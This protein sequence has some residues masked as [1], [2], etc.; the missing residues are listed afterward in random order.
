MKKIEDYI[1]VVPDALS[2][3]ECDYLLKYYKNSEWDMA[4]VDDHGRGFKPDEHV[5]NCYVTPVGQPRSYALMCAKADAAIKKY[6]E[7]TPLVVTR[8]NSGFDMLKYEEGGFYK[9]HADSMPQVPRVLS[10]SWALNDDFEGGEWGF[11]GN[12]HKFSAPKG[13][14]VVFPSNFVYPHQINPIT[15]G[16]RYSIVTWLV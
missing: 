15:K 4:L 12:E 16:T 8:G 9:E 11:F 14:L 6:M 10:C 7:L 5:R 13:S 3:D 1:L 2:S